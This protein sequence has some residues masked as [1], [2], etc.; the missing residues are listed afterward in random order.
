MRK[1][2]LSM[3][4]MLATAGAWAQT[5]PVVADGVYTIKNV[6]NSRGTMCFGSKNGTEYFGLADITLTTPSDFRGN[7]VTI[8]QESK[9]HWYVKNTDCGTYIY[10][11][12]KALFFQPTVTDAKASCAATPGA[13]TLV[14]EDKSG[15]NYVNIKN[16]NTNNNYI[17]FAC[18]W[19]PSQG[20]FRWGSLDNGG[21]QLTFTAVTDGNT[22]YST[23]IAAADAL[24]NAA[25]NAGISETLAGNSA[26]WTAANLIPAGLPQL[27]NYTNFKKETMVT[28]PLRKDVTVSI[29][30]TGGSHG[31]KIYGVDL[32]DANGVVLAKSYSEKQAGGNKQPQVY[33][34]SSVPAGTYLLRWYVGN[35]DTH[36]KL[37]YFNGTAETT[38]AKVAE[39]ADIA[40]FFNN[41]KTAAGTKYNSCS[42]DKINK[43][44]YY[45]TVSMDRLAGVKDVTD[46]TVANIGSLAEAIEHMEVVLPVTGKFYRIKN[47]AGNAYLICGNSGSAQ[48]AADAAG[49]SKNNVFYL[50]ENN[51]LISYSN[52]LYFTISSSQ[53]IYKSTVGESTDAIF[54]FRASPVVGKLYISFNSNG[55][56]FLNSTGIGNTNAGTDATADQS[57]L[58]NDAGY[59]FTVEEV[60]YLPVSMTAAVGYATMYSPVNLKCSD[61][62]NE[63]VKAYVA[64]MVNDGKT[65]ILLKECTDGIPANTAVILKYVEGGTIE[66]ATGCLYLHVTEEEI[67]AP[68]GNLL[69][70]TFAATNITSEGYVLSNKNGIGL[71]KALMNNGSWL[72]NAFKAYLPATALDN[73]SGVEV[74]SLTFS[75]DTETGIENIDGTQKENSNSVIYDLSGRRV[76]SAQ[77]G[78]YIINGK[79][80]I[81]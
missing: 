8:E 81:K 28:V 63:R 52:G 11:V 22:T 67:G 73:N 51:K 1:L 41:I 33:T 43:V 19:T 2:L 66:E 6:Y 25:E 39:S 17:S 34:L 7:S 78:I 14:N 4:L 24:I 15:V 45:N 35:N 64:T 71:Y 68:E 61:N 77:K 40:T 31:L 72:N 36:N 56:R 20:Q 65:S 10:N 37:T 16:S 48:T 69:N 57:G 21:S 80:V 59:R 60:E 18:G 30:Y 9:S 70:G 49:N 46:G 29:V 50:A 32:V 26:W 54:G 55:Q 13:L 47:N 38:G 79:K 76:Q 42:S 75:F 23:Q 62:G 53:L 12:G 58:K 3:S 27:A 44:G 74:R 5:S